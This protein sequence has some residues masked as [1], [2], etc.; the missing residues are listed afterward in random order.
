MKTTRLMILGLFAIVALFAGA[1][2]A[3]AQYYDTG[4]AYRDRFTTYRGGG[5][6]FAFP[7]ASGSYA[8]SFNQNS[9]DTSRNFFNT[10]S[11]DNS[12]SLRDNVFTQSIGT[13]INLN[14]NLLDSRE[15]FTTT[16]RGGQYDTGS[17]NYVEG[18][19]N[20][21]TYKRELEGRSGGTRAGRFRITETIYGGPQVRY[22]RNFGVGNAFTTT[23]SANNRAFTDNFNSNAQVVNNQRNSN[24]VETNKEKNTFNDRFTMR[25][26]QFGNGFNLVFN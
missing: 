3:E 7:R 17:I 25:E 2:V 19:A 18:D 15:A 8:Q 23:Q 26:T 16:Q 22:N 24:L 5:N 12:R 4:S 6:Y 1:F 11:T 9:F 20:L 14:R 21:V 13:N 10:G